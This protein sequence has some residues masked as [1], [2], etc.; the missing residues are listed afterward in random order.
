MRR[1]CGRGPFA[2]VML[3]VAA[4]YPARACEF[5]SMQGQ[6]LVDDVNQAA[7]VLFGRLANAKLDP[8]GD[9]GQGTT[10]LHIEAVIKKHE[11]LAGRKV[12][13]LPRYLP[14]EA[15]TPRFLI[16]C[17]FYKGAIDPYRGVPM[18]SGNDIVRYLQGA[19]VVRDKDVPI[20]LRYYFDFL[21]NADIEIAN[22]AYKN[23]ANA[24]ERDYQRMAKTLPADRIAHW[25]EDPS[26]PSFRFGLYAS[27]LGHCGTEKHAAI[28]RRMLDDAQKRLS[29]G[30]DGMLA[31][32]T[33]LKPA[34]GWPYIRAILGDASKEF[35]LRY[36]ALRAARFFHGKRPDLVDRK[37]V[38]EGVCLL[39]DDPN[40][41]DLAVDDLRQWGC[42]DAADRVL[43]LFDRPAFAASVLRKAVL[44]YALSCPLDKARSLV[45]EARKK[46]AELV[47]DAEE[48][49]KMEA[50]TP[51]VKAPGK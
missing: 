34:E 49:L 18:K 14:T 27:M 35:T 5:C 33:M 42:W 47:A 46:D 11:F 4:V 29:A 36:A 19:L 48:A 50:G 25:L 43:G 16:F 21:D 24:D 1:L 26:T 15:N 8:K 45:S 17:D 13:I 40:I 41:A 22:D 44:K 28:L 2:A 31:G 23:F 9:A 30:V 37:K 38:V 6:T 10:E 7:M 20:R 32:Y 3:L 12:L 51:A 39:L